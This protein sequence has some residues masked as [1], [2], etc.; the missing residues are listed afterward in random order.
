MVAGAY[1]QD[2]MYADYTTFTTGRPRHDGRARETGVYVHRSTRARVYHSE[3][4]PRRLIDAALGNKV[5]PSPLLST[6]PAR[7]Q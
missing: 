7:L 6:L 5:A 4:Y 2:A 1:H 3:V